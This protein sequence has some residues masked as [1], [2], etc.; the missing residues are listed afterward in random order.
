MCAEIKSQSDQ[1]QCYEHLHFDALPGFG[2]ILPFRAPLVNTKEVPLFLA[3]LVA[4]FSPLIGVRKRVMEQNKTRHK[5]GRC[6]KN[7][8]KYKY[9]DAGTKASGYCVP[10]ATLR[11]CCF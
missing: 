6:A 11:C 3:L 8:S 10:S 7:Q 1:Q 5:S 4:R 9:G 2:W